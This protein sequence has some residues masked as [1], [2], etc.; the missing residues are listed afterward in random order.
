VTEADP[1]RSDLAQSGYEPARY[2]L[3]AVVYVE[4]GEEI[5]LLQRAEGSALAGQWFLPGGMVEPGE[6]PEDGARRELREEAGVE[7]DGELELV[8]AYP[9]FVY[10]TETLQLSYRGRLATGGEVAISHEHDGA[11]WVDPAEMRALLSDEVLEQIAGG[12]DDVR[13]ILTHVRVDLDRYLART[14]SPG[15]GG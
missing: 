8:G 6:L 3:S 7:I 5:L 2:A 12:R 1:L 10:G 15:P 11:R 4:R 13:S 14:R 9:M